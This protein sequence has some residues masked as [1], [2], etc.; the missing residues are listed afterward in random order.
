MISLLSAKRNKEYY[1]KDILQ[2]KDKDRLLELGFI[3]CKII[4]KHIGFFKGVFL[5]SLRGFE[6]ILSKDIAK[7][8][9]IGCMC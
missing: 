3:N 1:I 8:I 5:V 4:V 2:N 7:N 9:L 6:I